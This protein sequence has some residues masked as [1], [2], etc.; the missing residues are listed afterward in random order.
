MASAQAFGRKKPIRA[1]SNDDDDDEDEEPAR[2]PSKKDAKKPSRAR[3]ASLSDEAK[4]PAGLSVRNAASHTVLGAGAGAMAQG[5]AH[6]DA[7]D[8]LDGAELAAQ[9]EEEDRKYLPVSALRVSQVLPRLLRLL[10][11]YALWVGQSAKLFLHAQAQLSGH[12][13]S[14]WETGAEQAVRV[15]NVLLNVTAA[16][17]DTVP[18]HE[19]CVVVL[20]PEQQHQAS[21]YQHGVGLNSPLNSPSTAKP[22][23]MDITAV[24]LDARPPFSAPASVWEH[25]CCLFWL[26]Q[27]TLNTLTSLRV[28]IIEDL[29]HQVFGNGIPSAS[30][31]VQ[32][33]SE[34]F[35]QVGSLISLL[36]RWGP[37]FEVIP[38]L[39]KVDNAL[40]SALLA[41]H[42][43]RSPRRDA[44][45]CSQPFASYVEARAL[46]VVTHRFLSIVGRPLREWDRV[47]AKGLLVD[48]EQGFSESD[49][50]QSRRFGQNTPKLGAAAA[51]DEDLLAQEF[52]SD[53]GLTMV[54][55]T[56]EAR[57]Q[58]QAAAESAATKARQRESKLQALLFTMTSL[59]QDLLGVSRA[60]T[61]HPALLKLFLFTYND[62]LLQLL[63]QSLSVDSLALPERALVAEWLVYYQ[64]LLVTVTQAPVAAS[65]AATPSAAAS[66]SG[67]TP[68]DPTERI[69]KLLVGEVRTM[70]LAFTREYIATVRDN[71]FRL[72]ENVL[73]HEQRCLPGYS[74]S[75]AGQHGK[76]ETHAPVDVFEV[77]HTFTTALI[78]RF[79]LHT[80]AAPS[81]T[82][83]EMDVADRVRVVEQLVQVLGT[84]QNYYFKALFMQ[85]ERVHFAN[86][87]NRGG[88][89]H[90]YEYH[91]RDF[92]HTPPP[93][94]HV[95]AVISESELSGLRAL[96]VHRLDAAVLLF[97]IATK[98]RKLS[99]CG[100]TGYCADHAHEPTACC[101]AHAE[102][103]VPQWLYPQRALQ[104]RLDTPSHARKLSDAAY[105]GA[106]APMPHICVTAQLNNASEYARQSAALW[107]R[108]ESLLHH[109]GARDGDDSD[110]DSD[111]DDDDVDADAEPETETETPDGEEISVATLVKRARR[112]LETVRDTVDDYIWRSAAQCQTTLVMQGLLQV[113]KRLANLFTDAWW[114]GEAPLEPLLVD[115]HSY[116]K[117]VVVGVSTEQSA[118]LNRMLRQFLRSLCYAYVSRCVAAVCADKKRPE[119]AQGL[120]TGSKP[121]DFSL[122]ILSDKLQA[123][124]VQMR[125]FAKDLSRLFLV[126]DSVGD[127]DGDADG[128]G[129]SSGA[130]PVRYR[131]ADFSEDF[132][133]VSEL[134]L[135]LGTDNAA[136]LEQVSALHLRISGLRY[137]YDSASA[138]LRG[139]VV[140]SLSLLRAASLLKGVSTKDTDRFVAQASARLQAE[141]ALSKPQPSA[142]PS[143]RRRHQLL[144]LLECGRGLEAKNKNG[145]DSD[146]YV[147]M[148]LRDSAG[149]SLEKTRSHTVYE[150]LAPDWNQMLR[151][152]GKSWAQSERLEMEIF[153]SNLLTFNVVM[154]SATRT[155]H[156]IEQRCL[157]RA[158]ARA[159]T[160]K[161]GRR[162][163]MDGERAKARELAVAAVPNVWGWAAEEVPLDQGQGV[164]WV[165]YILAADTDE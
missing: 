79:K 113:E 105:A 18:L 100:R 130:H 15:G 78:Q 103:R 112:R 73:T 5:E 63:R 75:L 32:R 104:G 114:R 88:A 71:L 147:V 59:T 85:Q 116:V 90:P 89:F 34:G 48:P 109:A 83:S 66:L 143:V 107:E 47:R 16:N 51:E 20:A 124:C 97:S 7:E 45:V 158:D 3:A 87:S 152:R 29:L 141:N 21:L 86:L 8:A 40:C 12:A 93:L 150:T 164:I 49:A 137:V 144:V 101:M 138:L 161:T 157:Q 122:L 98:D 99:V 146:P 26:Q 126:C 58:A 39:R 74:L 119:W 76:F 154:G 60:C 153:D 69:F 30:G 64:G 55:D 28:A 33:P 43:C 68:Q 110:G 50:F 77:L 56:G 38:P 128:D 133:L 4:P 165:T 131:Q 160:R 1:K 162:A 11:H 6:A 102:L 22:A 19:V 132:G 92:L 139:T 108:V 140:D 52:A 62:L 9:E 96:S 13:P 106:S 61:R 129:S 156:A 95:N 25:V 72:L 35:E 2:K 53:L 123:D 125:D 54:A 80:L 155:T 145:A 44:L 27:L 111:D 117:A 120:H 118:V 81:P 163:S 135:A 121:K 23:A 151:F 142:G 14:A 46:D 148:R 57:A 67:S 84:T 159:N 115:L 17:L 127:V 70:K 136:L 10:R 42:G 134:L 24:P 36:L 37:T 149:R 91:A 65:S 31:A 82:D 94:P 41:L